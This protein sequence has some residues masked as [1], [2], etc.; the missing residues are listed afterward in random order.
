MFGWRGGGGAKERKERHV[1]GLGVG[2]KDEKG[3]NVDKKKGLT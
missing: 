3:K 2:G 1:R